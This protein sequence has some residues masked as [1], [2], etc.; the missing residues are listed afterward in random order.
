MR[1]LGGKSK[2]EGNLEERKYGRTEGGRSLWTSRVLISPS[3]HEGG[4][5]DLGAIESPDFTNSGAVVFY[6]LERQTIKLEGIHSKQNS[7]SHKPL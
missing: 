4:G 3:D 6:F 2:K 5:R 1:G 7:L